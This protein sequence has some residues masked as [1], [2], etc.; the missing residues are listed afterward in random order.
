[1][2]KKYKK[3][4]TKPKIKGYPL[5]KTG[6]R[7]VP[8]NANVFQ[9]F[10]Y[11]PSALFGDISSEFT[12]VIWLAIFA[13]AITTFNWIN[14]I[15]DTDLL[16]MTYSRNSLYYALF[17]ATFFI[18]YALG[19]FRIKQKEK[20]K[21][22]GI[23]TVFNVSA[24]TF[25]NP[26]AKDIV[27]I[28]IYSGLTLMITSI[29]QFVIAFFIE[30]QKFNVTLVEIYIFYA[31]SGIAEEFFFRYFFYQ[32]ILALIKRTSK[33]LA[34]HISIIF[35]GIIFGL[36]HYGVYGQ[37]PL[38]ML[39]VT[40]GGIV[41]GYSY[42]LSGTL[43]VPIISHVANNMIATAVAASE[44]RFTIESESILLPC[45]DVGST[46][47]SI[48]ILLL[49]TTVVFFLNATISR[50]RQDSKELNGINDMNN[51]NDVDTTPV[52]GNKNENKPINWKNTLIILTIIF[53]SIIL[54]WIGLTGLGYPE[55]FDSI[56]GLK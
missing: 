29:I 49:V 55:Y 38:L 4:M 28:T 37:Q 43:I 39:S 45:T 19:S 31:M 36:F 22:G 20:G 27:N 23:Y 11:K 33:I 44:G 34:P 16:G 51:L 56:F 6:L 24:M 15:N 21:N 40:L 50:K 7:Q 18:M 41:L 2:P 8:P 10:Y 3:R 13:T 35:A 9:Q 12:I 42:I 46:G 52:N 32:T 30:A 14:H 1:M 53:I 17:S 26:T 25:V 47:T 48:I 54:L 5:K